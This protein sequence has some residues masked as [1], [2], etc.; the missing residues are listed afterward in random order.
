MNKI[1]IMRHGKSIGNEKNIIQGLSDYSLC[2]EGIVNLKEKD[3]NQL[4]NVKKI[5]SSS[6]KRSVETASIIKDKINCSNPVI[7]DKRLDEVSLGILDGKSKNY[8]ETNY[9][10]YYEV[11]KK[12]GDYDKI[13]DA[14]SWVYTQAR[15]IAFLDKYIYSDNE[16][17]LIVSHASYIRTLINMI[18]GRDRNTQF[19]IDNG[20]L[21]QYDDPLKNIDIYNYDIAKA[22]IVK[23]VQCYDNKYIMKK[24]YLKLGNGDYMEKDILEYLSSYFD[25]PLDIYMF[26]NDEYMIKISKYLEGIHIFGELSRNKIINLVKKVKQLND[27]LLKYPKESFIRN[28]IIEELKQT[29]SILLDENAK[30]KAN[31]LLQDERLVNYINNGDYNLVHNDLHRSNI[32]FDKNKVNLIDFE[33]VKMYPDLLQISTLICSAFLLEGCIDSL[34]VILNNWGSKIDIELVKK[35]IDYRLLYGLSFFDNKIRNNDYDVSDIAIKKKYI[36]ALR[37]RI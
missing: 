35:L 19:N 6:L 8:C 2:E 24:R 22:S 11:F 16:N 27:C 36:K 7:I 28:N 32:L 18:L 34:D 17:D 1:S 14:D 15:V 26:D 9:P 29:R 10:E 4:A 23:R 5:Y 31:Q 12:R 30:I 37:G 25:V 33:S 21:F 3:Y 13:L 20:F